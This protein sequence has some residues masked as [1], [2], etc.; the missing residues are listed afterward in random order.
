[1]TPMTDK[2]YFM[3]REDE[4]VAN[5]VIKTNSTPLQT[6]IDIKIISP[7]DTQYEPQFATQSSEKFDRIDEMNEF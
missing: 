2:A 7:D 4:D 5:S 6:N 1:M 3:E